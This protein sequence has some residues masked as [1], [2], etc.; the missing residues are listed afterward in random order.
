MQRV[1][2]KFIQS[3]VLAIFL[4]FAITQKVLAADS[5]SPRV[6]GEISITTNEIER[7]IS[8]T[9]NSFGMMPSFGYQWAHAELGLYGSN[10]QYPDN[11]E[12][13]NLRPFAWFDFV[14]SPTVDLKARYDMNAYFPSVLRNGNLYTLDLNIQNHHVVAVQDT[15]WYG[16]TTIAYW[17]GYVHRWNAF[18]DVDYKVDLGYQMVYSINYQSFFAG[19]VGFAYK[20]SDFD[21]S[22]MFAA[23]SNS[24]QFLNNTANPALFFE[25]STKF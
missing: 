1:T 5:D 11:L 20:Y 18:G 17:L 25:I 9:N 13:L 22:L 6:F 24:T 21:L 14:F 19:Q 3:F 7:G 4:I 16:T 12:N 10:V 23:N 15:N 8:V 2:T